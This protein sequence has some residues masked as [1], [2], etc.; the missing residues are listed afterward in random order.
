MHLHTSCPHSVCCC[1]DCHAIGNEV[2]AWGLS[3]V[4]FSWNCSSLL[5]LICQLWLVAISWMGSLEQRD[6]AVSWLKTSDAALYSWWAASWLGTLGL[7]TKIVPVSLRELLDSWWRIQQSTRVIWG[8]EVS[9]LVFGSKGGWEGAWMYPSAL[10]KIQ[11]VFISNGAKFALILWLTDGFSGCFFG[12]F[13]CWLLDESC[14]VEVWVL[15]HAPFP[16]LHFAQYFHST[17][18]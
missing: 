12:P 14:S 10:L 18:L 11:D 5:W 16:V 7:V 4:A 2:R 13:L 15:F 6:P 3:L 9:C 8:S 17:D 1:F